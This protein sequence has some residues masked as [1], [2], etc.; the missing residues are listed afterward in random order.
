MWA[1]DFKINV[2]DESV[3]TG[4][5]MVCVGKDR[6]TIIQE[7]NAGLRKLALS[8]PSLSTPILSNSPGEI[9]TE[10]SSF[11]EEEAYV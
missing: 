1:S 11:S 10:E 8:S 7:L 6:D 3:V 4:T 2:V 5:K 9:P